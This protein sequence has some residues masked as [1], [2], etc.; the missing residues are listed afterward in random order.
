MLFEYNY[1]LC[2]IIHF[3]YKQLGNY[4][5]TSNWEATDTA[6]EPNLNQAIE[7]TAL[8]QLLTMTVFLVILIVPISWEGL[9]KKKNKSPA[10]SRFWK[11]FMSHKMLSVA[12]KFLS[13][14]SFLC[15]LIEVTHAQSEKKP[16][17]SKHYIEKS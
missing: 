1:V 14:Y 17:L 10:F 9:K 8:P 5:I 13:K 6:F 12:W 11:I 16:K 7:P 2:W 15:V 4:I 3:F